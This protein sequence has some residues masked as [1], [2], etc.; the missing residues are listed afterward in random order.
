M[1]TPIVGEVVE[2]LKTMPQELRLRVL[3]FA[4]ALAQSTPRGVPGRELRHL[5]GTISPEDAEQMRKAIEEGCE[6]QGTPGRYMSTEKRDFDKEAD[7]WDEHPARVQLANDVAGVISRQVVLRPDMDVL[8]FGCGTG[9]LT[10][11]LAP[12]VKSITG[13]DSSRGML[14]V[15]GAKIARQNLTN[16]RTLLLDLEAGDTLR[17]EYHL[18]VSNMTLHHV[19]EVGPLLER[20]YKAL[21]PGGHLC[22]ADLDPDDGL[23]HDDNQGVFHFG[24]KRAA[25]RQAFVGVGFE[26]V[27]DTT[28]AEVTKPTRLGE[29]RRFT[30][31]LM[32]GLRGDSR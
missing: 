13:V 21:A 9:L 7:A 28:A 18:I 12:L 15:L 23:F 24:F 26:D 20:F 5:A 31:F 6:R 19:R 3:E 1:D 25:L 22:I 4:R 11:Q 2:Q 17:D 14:N 8:D 32:T 27:Q 16:V 30:V 10:L 29:Q